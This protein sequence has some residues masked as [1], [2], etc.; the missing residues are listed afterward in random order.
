M[1][2][3]AYTIGTA[4]L[5]AAVLAGC[6]G[7]P[8][9][10]GQ[11]DDSKPGAADVTT[12]EAEP[13][14]Y[15]TLP[16][17]CDAVGEG[18][19]EEMLPGLRQITDAKKR[20]AAYEGTADLTYDLDRRV[21]CHWQAGS[22]DSTDSLSLD[23]E[24]VVSYEPA[25]GDDDKAGEIFTDLREEAGVPAPGA[26]SS[27]S[28]DGSSSPSEPA[29]DADAA[30]DGEDGTDGEDAE[31]SSGSPEG[32]AGSGGAADLGP[33]PLEDLGDEA[34]LDDSLGTAGTTSSERTVT[35][36][37]RTSNVI[38][39]IVRTSRPTLAGETTDGE[40]MQD[41][42]RELAAALAEELAG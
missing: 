20:E 41:R 42:A 33:R 24:R 25:V 40:E 13:G 26:G 19:L 36:V 16:D 4:A 8:S 1:Q 9:E 28:P 14:R 29:S 18:T 22:Q 37:F 15:R 17:P 39:K 30:T 2:R 7:G 5:L 34:F 27:A 10:G 31:P 12:A 23:F 6:S 38:V 11:A 35:V 32:S 21:G 3:K